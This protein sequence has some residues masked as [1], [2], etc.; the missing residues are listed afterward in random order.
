MH[1][2]AWA[3][4][5]MLSTSVNASSTKA[6]S[7]APLGSSTSSSQY[8]APVV[9]A[10]HLFLASN[11]CVAHHHLHVPGLSSPS[12]FLSLSSLVS[13]VS[14]KQTALAQR[15]AAPARAAVS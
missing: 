10:I 8:R 1:D 5:R 9:C 6:S 13:R 2:H 11:A 4:A 7:R 15:P 12:L 3:M 14:G